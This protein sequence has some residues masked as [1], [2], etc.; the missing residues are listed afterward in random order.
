[1]EEPPENRIPVEVW[2]HILLEVI[3][4][5]SSPVFATTCTSSN[6]LAY[7]RTFGKSDGFVYPSEYW[8]SEKNRLRVRCVC[9]TWRAFADRWDIRDRWVITQTLWVGRDYDK[10]RGVVRLDYRGL[11][12]MGDWSS[13]KEN[14]IASLTPAWLAQWKHIEDTGGT[15]RLQR[16]ELL[17]LRPE[18]FGNFIRALFDVASLSKNLRSLALTI[19]NAQYPIMEM[20][21][22]HLPN[23]TH[24]TLCMQ[25]RHPHGF[26]DNFTTFERLGPLKL[27]K[28]EVLFL[29]PN[30]HTFDLP[31]WHLPSLRHIQIRLVRSLWER[32]YEFLERHA[33][34]IETID[35]ETNA[36]N[37]MFWGT[38]E[39]IFTLPQ[40]F[41]STFAH[42]KLLR[43]SWR[44]FKFEGLPPQHHPLETFV[45][46]DSI[47][48]MFQITDILEVWVAEPGIKHLDQLVVHGTYLEG[49]FI[50][51]NEPVQ[52]LIRQLA[53]KGTKLLSPE[54]KCWNEE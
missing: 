52:E 30:G 15:I 47:E 45:V 33:P 40:D 42:L 49:H 26:I 6:Y 34:T 24:L 1:M 10:W 35:L 17:H 31:T 2:E 4:V 21:A 14:H 12:A 3:S 41:W 22:N 11:G 54:G 27:K 5:G 38:Q 51:W 25:P 16:L 36:A 44:L 23:L 29:F 28:L 43:C 53:N 48:E 32:M 8:Q 18:F 39:R 13:V 50:K 9:R 19:P 7:K 20:V 37:S 46:T